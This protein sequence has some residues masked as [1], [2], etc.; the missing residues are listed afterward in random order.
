VSALA[1]C[2]AIP[3]VFWD[4]S[5]SD[6]GFVASGD[7]GQWSWGVPTSGPGGA[8]AVWATRL[9]GDYLNDAVE[10][11]ELPAL[12]LSGLTRPV[13][14][15]R[16]WYSIQPGDVGR[17][18]VDDGGGF[19]SVDPI[20]GYPDAG[21]FF[22]ASDWIYTSLDLSAFGNAPRVRL[23]FS[24]DPSLVDEGWYL[25]SVGLYDGD[26]TPPR[27]SVLV[28]PADTQELDAPYA[29]SLD[30][31]DDVG[32]T[33]IDVHYTVNGGAE[34]TV[35]AVDS[36]SG[37]WDAGIPAQA[38]DSDVSWFAVATDGTE[39]TRLPDAGGFDFRVFLAAPENVSGPRGSR[40]VDNQVTLTWDPPVSPHPV[41]AYVV[42]D[43]VVQ[44]EVSGLEAT[45]SLTADAPTTWTVAARYDVGIGD[46]SD[47]V[48][49]EV[50]VPDLDPLDPSAAFQGDTVRVVL[51]GQSLYLFEGTTTLDLG[52]GVTVSALQVLDVNSA[53]AIVTVSEEAET[54]LRDLS[55][56]G[57]QGLFTFP[58][59]FEV[60]DG[61]ESPQVLS[62]RPDS[63]LQGEALTVRITVSEPFAGPVTLAETEDLVVTD[64][65]IDGDVARI[66]LVVNNSARLGD[67]PLVLDD[68][69]R[70]WTT[71]FEVRER[72]FRT[73]TTCLGCATGPNPGLGWGV[74][75]LLLVRRR[76]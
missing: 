42:D 74:L 76:R 23:V 63:G 13:L 49:V 54:G 11:L 58:E 7:I 8:D 46:P 39:I 44:T 28:A 19:T 37:V 56:T 45:L 29:V 62:T 60:L 10:V 24:A 18:E 17:F 21:G 27:V 1:L 48:S 55:L 20:Y 6:H 57:T 69:A 3:V 65:G 2:A 67:H 25:S 35:V 53:T 40:L 30:A 75:L 70:L 26:V 14:V 64:V 50:E 51:Q 33:G 16:H 4:L 38:P 31:V 72:V 22:G 9:D 73:S 59:A 41:V 43:T 52:P 34:Q 68:G 61:A 36:G 32:V 47:P 66:E 5:I 15:F 12:D 71:Q